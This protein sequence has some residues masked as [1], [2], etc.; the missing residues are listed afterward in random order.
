[1]LPHELMVLHIHKLTARLISIACKFSII[2]AG[3]GEG[4]HKSFGTLQ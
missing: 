1:M 4:N 3:G 2:I